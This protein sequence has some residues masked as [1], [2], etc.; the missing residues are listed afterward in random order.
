MIENKENFKA[1]I[2]T[3]I[4]EHGFPEKKVTLPLEKMY[5]IAETKKLNL[6]QILEE[7]CTEGILHNKVA[8]KILFYQQTGTDEVD[9]FNFDKNSSNGQSRSA[10][11]FQ[12]NTYKSI[13]ERFKGVD[14]KSPDFMQKTQEILSTLPP[15][16]LKKIQEL[17]NSISPA[18]REELMK[19]AKD[20]GL[21]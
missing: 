4:Y 18:E 6:N 16:E 13:F 8:D 15:E 5:E 9:N 1:R 21:S 11:Y 3:T 10:D 20:M 14:P 2:K 12:D 7:L 19:R 17:Y